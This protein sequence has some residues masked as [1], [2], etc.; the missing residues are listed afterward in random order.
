MHL[1][2]FPQYFVKEGKRRPV[3]YTGDARDLIARGWKPEV[4]E[5][6]STVKKTSITEQISESATE[7]LQAQAPVQVEEPKEAP[8][9]APLPFDIVDDDIN[10]LS[11]F[12]PD[13]DSF[14]KAELLE[15]AL[16][17]GVDLRNNAPKAEILAECKE[18]FGG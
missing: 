4:K 6:K 10:P 17:R 2:N 1:R 13:F 18:R 3:Y 16:S 7:L 8:A 12:G 9:Q 14:T 11:T 5:T 15:Y